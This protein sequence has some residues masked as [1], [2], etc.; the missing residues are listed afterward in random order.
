MLKNICY[1]VFLI[2]CIF[3]SGQ[4]KQQKKFF[5]SDSSLVKEIF[6]YSVQDS[7]LEGS[8]ESF[9]IN[10]SLQTFGWY[11][12]NQP[13]S[14]W[15]YYYENGRPKAIGR[16]YNGYPRGKWKFYYENG[17]IKS[18][19]ILKKSEKNGYWRFYYENGGEKSNGNYF[20]NQKSGIWN[21]FYEDGSLKA[22]AYMENGQGKYTEFY[23]SGKRRMEGYNENEKSEGEWTY[24]YE[25]GEVEATGSFENGLKTGTWIYYH[26]NGVVA[27]EGKY[28]KGSR[29]GD[30]TYYHDNG[31]V[32]QEGKIV[33]DQKDGFWK[34]FYPSGELLGEGNFE[35]GSGY[36][37]E[38]YPS[39]SIKSRGKLSEGEK[40]GKWL[41]YG[42]NGGLEGEATFF[43]NEG[44][45]IGYYPD[46]TIKMTGKLKDDKRIGEWVLYNSDGSKAG[47]YHPIY[48][49]EKPIF[50]T[51]ISE[52]NK[53]T[54]NK[55]EYKFKKKGFKYFKPTINEYWGIIMESNPVWLFVDQLPIA[56]EY[57]LQERLGYQLQLD[58]L[59]DPFFTLEDNIEDYQRYTRGSRIHFRQKFY[60]SD[61][62]NGM[63]YFGHELS[64]KY[65]DHRVNHLDTA[66]TNAVVRRF[67]NMIETG[68]GYGIFVGNRWMRD[69][70][71]SGFTIDLYAGISIVR[72]SFSK[73]YLNNSRREVQ[74]LDN[75]FESEIKSSVHFPFQ[76]GLHIGFM[77]PKSKS[78]T[79]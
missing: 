21:Y 47:T 66:I 62:T 35:K 64:F 46:G 51:R 14:I 72:R 26:K 8:Y 10:G 78:K 68:F 20:D 1:T 16:Y 57:Y 17:N 74:I 41:Y 75:Y 23:P 73:K 11:H 36:Y 32:S 50:K 7:T 31:K 71:N 48:E 38:Y 42:E 59:R 18:E 45:Y 19:G 9:Y 44:E 6:H 53:E 30:W 77:V 56:V 52:R 25:S 15:K 70:G 65:L 33:N 76:I 28:L 55:P 39:G 12:K 34:L 54:Y 40:N 5:E 58:L 43:Q 79:Q 63:L 4:K 67:G 3:S 27:A 22:Q 24:Y 13:D 49:N 61:R 69:V 60:S 29:I 2:L 37:N